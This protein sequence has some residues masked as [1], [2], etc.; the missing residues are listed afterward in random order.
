IVETAIELSFSGYDFYSKS[1]GGGL[2]IVREFDD[3]LPHLLCSPSEI[4]Q[5]L[6]NLLKN[7][8]QAILADQGRRVDDIARITIRLKKEVGFIRLEIEDNGPGMSPETR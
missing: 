2:E 7:S 3:S 1:G 5:V 4:E 6:I 8:V